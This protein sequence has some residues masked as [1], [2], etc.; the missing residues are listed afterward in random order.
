MPPLDP[1]TEE[2]KVRSRQSGPKDHYSDNDSTV[3][4]SS[5]GFIIAS[6]NWSDDFDTQV[7]VSSGRGQTSKSEK[8]ASSCKKHR[9]FETD[10]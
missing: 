5:T 4:A 3:G 10:S 6:D 9:H 1:V 8:T 2:A 7:L